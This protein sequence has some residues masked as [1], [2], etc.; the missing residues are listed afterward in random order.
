[1]RVLFFVAITAWCLCQ[2]ACTEGATIASFKR[3]ESDDAKGFL[4]VHGEFLRQGNTA[5]PPL[6]N[7]MSGGKQGVGKS[8]TDRALAIALGIQGEDK[9]S[10]IDNIKRLI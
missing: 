4:A 3:G 9:D 1:M 7:V 8:T 6:Y 2:L 10:Q 5:N